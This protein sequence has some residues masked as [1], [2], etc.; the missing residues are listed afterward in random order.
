VRVCLGV[1]A[2]FEDPNLVSCAGL[3]PVLELAE[4]A[5]LMTWSPSD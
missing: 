1:S 3:V 2:T 5:G 4:Q